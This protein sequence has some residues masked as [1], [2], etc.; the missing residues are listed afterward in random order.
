MST[1]KV[2][3]GE[4]DRA[5]I[6]GVDVVDEI[7]ALLADRLPFVPATDKAR[8]HLQDLHDVLAARR[9]SPRRR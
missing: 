5:T 3:D 8:R 1:L 6:P 9:L 7:I 4:Q 2:L